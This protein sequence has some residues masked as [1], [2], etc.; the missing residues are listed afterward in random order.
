MAAEESVRASHLCVA[1]AVIS[2]TG[3]IGENAGLLALPPLTSANVIPCSLAEGGQFVDYPDSGHRSYGGPIRTREEVA[4]LVTHNIW[5]VR[6]DSTQLDLHAVD[7]QTEVQEQV[8]WNGEKAVRLPLT[9]RFECGDTCF[10]L[11]VLPG[12]HVVA[13]RAVSEAS[14][15]A[16][17]R[18]HGQAQF[19]AEAG[20]LY[21]LHVC[22]TKKDGRVFWVRDERSQACVSGACPG[23]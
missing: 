20:G 21:S 3:C 9:L 5:F 1:L 2:S 15:K 13:L 22:R 11:A 14:G 16:K 8:R 7:G 19:L 10:R 17:L 12:R 23:K 6:S 4:V 18:V